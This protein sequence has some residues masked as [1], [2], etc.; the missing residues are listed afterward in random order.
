MELVEIFIRTEQ[1]HSC[2]RN[3]YRVPLGYKSIHSASLC[4]VKEAGEHQEIPVPCYAIKKVSRDQ[5]T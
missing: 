3:R 4:Q 2:S 5:V 1:S